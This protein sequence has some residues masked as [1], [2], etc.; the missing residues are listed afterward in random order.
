VKEAK[1]YQIMVS[2]GWIT[3]ARVA[4]ELTGTKFSKNIKQLLKE[5]EQKAEE[6]VVPLAEPVEDTPNPDEVIGAVLEAIG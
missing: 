5:N 2:E 6:A 3:N 4:R 1:A